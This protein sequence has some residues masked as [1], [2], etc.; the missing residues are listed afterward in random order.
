MENQRYNA[1]NSRDSL[2]RRGFTF[3]ST[4]CMC[5]I[6]NHKTIHKIRWK[7]HKSKSIITLLERALTWFCKE[8]FAKCNYIEK[9]KWKVLKR[10]YI[11][12]LI[13]T[14]QSSQEMPWYV[15]VPSKYMIHHHTS[16]V[17]NCLWLIVIGSAVSYRSYD[18][19]TVGFL[20]WHLTTYIPLYCTAP[21]LKYSRRRW[22]MTTIIIRNCSGE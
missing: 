18:Q 16:I 2:T 20:Q 6:R 14:E 4:V 5:T 13:Q 19:E 7:T 9:I 8:I 1:M 10:K 22:L 15:F 12:E 21:T 3:D 11:L 17:C